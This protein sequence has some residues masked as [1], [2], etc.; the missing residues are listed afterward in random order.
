MGLLDYFG[1][2]GSQTFANVIQSPVTSSGQQYITSPTKTTSPI[3]PTTY[4]QPV[5]TVQQQPLDYPALHSFFQST[6]ILSSIY[7]A[8]QWFSQQTGLTVQLPT[9]QPQ[10]VSPTQSMATYPFYEVMHGVSQAYSKVIAEPFSSFVSSSLSGIPIAEQI[11][12]LSSGLVNAPTLASEYIGM[13]VPGGERLLSPWSGASVWRDPGGAAGMMGAGLALQG[14]ML[15]KGFTERPFETIGELGGMAL[16]FGGMSKLVS[17]SSGW[18]RTRGSSYLPIESIGYEPK[19]GFPMSYRQSASSLYRSFSESTL[20]PRPSRMSLSERVPYVPRSARLP[21]ESPL[22]KAMWTG[23]EKTPKT[24]S[25]LFEL[26]KGSS[27]IPGM[28]GAPVAESYFTKAGGQM[29]GLI[30]ADFSLLKRPS[31]VRTTVSGFEAVPRSVRSGGF[32]S[33]TRWI[34]G[35]GTA[36]RAYMPLLKPEY[37]AVLPKGNILR[38]TGSRYY[39]KVGGIGGSRWF[40]TRIPII[41]METTGKMGTATVYGGKLPKISYEAYRPAPLINLA[42]VGPSSVALSTRT[43][44]S[45]TTLPRTSVSSPGIYSL[46]RSAAYSGSIGGSSRTYTPS[47][48][49]SSSPFITSSITSSIVKPSYAPSSRPPS[50]PSYR[51]PSYAPPSYPSYKPPSYPSYRPPSYPP[52]RPP[53]Y[54]PTY[55]PPSYPPSL[56]P[57]YPPTLRPPSYPPTR[58]PTYIPTLITPPFP[59]AWRDTTPPHRAKKHKGRRKKRPYIKISPAWLPSRRRSPIR[60]MKKGGSLPK[61]GRALLKRL[62]KR[63]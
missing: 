25:G 39:T 27:E 47:Y 28:Y 23:W 49:P 60:T 46:S 36:G 6:P 9:V 54:L 56:P 43:G 50:Y 5:S 37:E 14:S 2:L 15:Y 63:K 29:P 18:I 53:S 10:P 57:S 22:T 26:G 7:G 8:G 62:L 61:D 51:L 55:R 20:Y 44:L 17:K 12:R 59:P 34:S 1:S 24:R 31:L 40:G 45:A 48:V 30:G 52:S 41:E 19:Y 32:E 33:I 38:I 13:A 16:L 42:Y 4:Q 3:Q 58:P 21:M 11:G 35:E